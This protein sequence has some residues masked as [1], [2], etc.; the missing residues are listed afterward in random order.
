M[1][2]NKPNYTHHDYSAHNCICVTDAGVQ[3]DGFQQS[4]Q[5]IN[6]LTTIPDHWHWSF[7][8]PSSLSSTENKTTP[9]VL[10][11]YS[12][13]I[14]QNKKAMCK[15]ILILIKKDWTDTWTVMI[16]VKGERADH[17]GSSGPGQRAAVPPSCPSA[18]HHKTISFFIFHLS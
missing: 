12:P 6:L 17:D 13:F 1:C 4:C 18:R 7:T 2:K 15:I 8:K 5:K 16:R 10:L 3:M 9:C 14:I 11:L